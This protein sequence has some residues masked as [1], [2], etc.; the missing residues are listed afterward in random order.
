MKTGKLFWG[1]F[2]LT[3]GALFLLSKY[4][5][6]SCSFGFVW[7]IW[8]LIFVFWGALVIFKETF[9]RPFINSLFGIFLALMLFGI[10]ENG[11]NSFDFSESNEV[12]SEFYEEN[13]DPGIK[14]ADLEISSGAGLF[15]IRGSTDK[16]AEGKTKG[17]IAEY[18][19]ELWKDDDHA[20]V[21]FKLHKRNFN[22]FRGRFKNQLEVALNQN[23]V[24]DINLNI[25]ASKSNFD[26]T[27][28]K[29]KNVSLHTGAA[30]GRIKLGDKFDSTTV[31][32]HMGAASI[33]VEIPKTSGCSINSD[34]ALVSRDFSGF[35]K[36]YSGYYETENF[37]SSS[38]K[39]FINVEGGVS[40]IKVKRY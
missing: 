28:Y 14:T 6:L 36:K 29:V 12:F 31:D 21:R 24:W 19:F 17:N 4:D 7:D 39:I 1:F 16:L 25:G 3:L 33:T 34:M 35:N 8:P 18:D 5:L 20:N 15:I 13:Y 9:A 2:L 22:F 27:E 10:M 37:K 38:K 11:I 26:L 32:I 23:P 40:S 30:S